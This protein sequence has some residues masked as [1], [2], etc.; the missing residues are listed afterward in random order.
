LLIG[1]RVSGLGAEESPRMVVTIRPV[2]NAERRM[3][4]Y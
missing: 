1:A 3:P 2:P 4:N